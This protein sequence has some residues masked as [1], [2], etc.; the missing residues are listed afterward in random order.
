[1]CSATLLIK[2]DSYFISHAAWLMRKK[3]EQSLDWNK[4]AFDF[5]LRLHFQHIQHHLLQ[6]NFL[7]TWKNVFLHIELS[8][9]R[10]TY[11]PYSL[12]YGDSYLDISF[13]STLTEFLTHNQFY[14]ACRFVQM[15]STLGLRE[16]FIISNRVK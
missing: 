12:W 7:H 10:E 9:T 15:S 5:L 3:C 4:Q 13:G 2:Y 1:M 14:S 16:V 8:I 6:Q 11:R